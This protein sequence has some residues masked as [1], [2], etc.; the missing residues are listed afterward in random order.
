MGNTKK[1]YQSLAWTASSILVLGSLL[2][3]FNIHPAYIYV[4]L[5]ANCMWTVVSF[6]WREPSLFLLNFGVLTI[7]IVGLIFG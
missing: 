2:A 6:L 7:Y 4:F 3:A 5:V 1:P